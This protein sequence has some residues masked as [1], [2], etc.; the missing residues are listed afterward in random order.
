MGY[1]SGRDKS[2]EIQKPIPQ[3]AGWMLKQS[4]SQ[5]QNNPLLAPPNVANP[6]NA[7]QRQIC[8]D[9]TTFAEFGSDNC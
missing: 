9:L 3:R 8:L 1:F 5:A 4:T 6:S 2:V 7:F